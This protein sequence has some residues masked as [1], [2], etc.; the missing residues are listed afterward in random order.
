LLDQDYFSS[1]PEIDWM[2]Y[3][4]D[5]IAEILHDLKRIVQQK[6]PSTPMNANPVGG[7]FTNPSLR[8]NG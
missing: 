1:M 2:L 6:D 7:L 4:D 3:K 8:S 5:R